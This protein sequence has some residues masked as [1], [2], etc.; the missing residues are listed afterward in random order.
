MTL[1]NRD[2]RWIQ[3]G[4]KAHGIKDTEGLKIALVPQED[5]SIDLVLIPHS[6][7]VATYELEEGET[8]VE[9]A[10]CI[11]DMLEGSEVRAPSG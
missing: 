9:L 8:I 10:E 5:E 4:L 1:S 7:T 11:Q 3:A 6:V 2:K